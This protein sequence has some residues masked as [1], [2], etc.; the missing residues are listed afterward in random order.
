MTHDPQHPDDERK[1]T[2]ERDGDDEPRD[3]HDNDNG[4]WN[5]WPHR[6]DL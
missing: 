1:P 3:F 2:P 5:Y 4:P 6:G